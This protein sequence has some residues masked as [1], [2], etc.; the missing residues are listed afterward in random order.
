MKY[1]CYI[2][3]RLVLVEFTKIDRIKPVY[4]VMGCLLSVGYRYKANYMPIEL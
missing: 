3:H 4:E 1:L 2:L